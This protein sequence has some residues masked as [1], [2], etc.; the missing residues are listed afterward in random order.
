MCITALCAAKVLFFFDIYKFFYIFAVSMLEIICIIL[1]SAMHIGNIQTSRTDSWTTFQNPACLVQP[2][3]FQFAA[4]YE[5]EYLLA[6]LNTA[7]IQMG[8]CNPYINI[9]VG[10]SFYGYSKYQEMQVGLTLARRFGRF[11][12]GI[13]ANYY[14]IYAGDDLK[15]KGTFIP[16]LGVTIDVTENF[17]I[18]AFS[19]NPFMQKIRI[20]DDEKRSVSSVYSLG[21]DYRF[22]KGFHW[23][24]QGDYDPVTTWRIATSIEWQCIDQLILKIGCYYREQVVACLG[25][26][27]RFDNLQIDTNFEFNPRLG[28]ILKARIGYMIP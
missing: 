27:M 8:Y 4:Q 2:A 22:Y 28:L 17:T 20:T 25:V 5:N 26:G 7:T 18:G 23:S 12:L 10:F 19:Y 3:R 9:G 24:L 1:T 11:S 21:T 13:G 16:E 15:Y 6:A 14:T